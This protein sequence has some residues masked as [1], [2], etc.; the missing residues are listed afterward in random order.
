M[1]D[2]TKLSTI[3]FLLNILLYLIFRAYHWLV[4]SDKDRD[5]KLY[6]QVIAIKIIGDAFLFVSLSVFVL[7]GSVSVAGKILD[8][9]GKSLEFDK[10]ISMEESFLINF[11]ALF[12]YIGIIF[13]NDMHKD[14]FKQISKMR[15]DL[16]K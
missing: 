14:I 7:F 1:V 9:F 13:M 3:I 16:S 15:G 10:A 12:S 11:V 8:Y 5:E 4:S 2:Y 6:Q